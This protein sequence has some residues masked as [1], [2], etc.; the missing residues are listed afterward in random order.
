MQIQ[1]DD[2]K[3][4]VKDPNLNIVQIAKANG[5]IIP[6][7]CF[8]TDHEFGCCKACAI[9]IKEKVHYACSTK[10]E[11]NMKIIFDRNNLNQL[12]IDRIKEFSENKQKGYI[13][14]CDCSEASENSSCGCG[15]GSG[16]C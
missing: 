8:N 15:C 11:D 2:K 3:I 16:C 1:I 7:P 12:R 5:I 4:E 9:E 14:E 10:P 6:A 13:S